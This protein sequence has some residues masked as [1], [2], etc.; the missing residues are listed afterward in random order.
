MEGV[1]LWSESETRDRE[2]PEG[3]ALWLG[4]VTH[5]PPNTPGLAHLHSQECGQGLQGA[6]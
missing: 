6:F 3:G 5:P 4:R 2:R 1:P